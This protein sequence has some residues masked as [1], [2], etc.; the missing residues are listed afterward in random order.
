M[1][2]Y[3]KYLVFLAVGLCLFIVIINTSAFDQTLRPEVQA[4]KDIK[5]HAYNRNNAYPALLAMSST[6]LDFENYSE[7]IRTILN[8]KIEQSGQDYLNGDEFDRFVDTSVDHEWQDDY[9]LCN[10]RRN[11][12]CMASL[13]DAVQEQPINQVRLLN[14]MKKY[15]RL[16]QFAEYSDPTQLDWE[17]PFVP[18]GPVLVMKRLYLA[19]SFAAQKPENF[20]TDFNQDMAF[21]R[22]LLRHG[23]HMITK[24][25]AVAS[26]NNSIDALSAALDEWRFSKQQL[27]NLHTVVSRLSQAEA[28]ME[29]VFVHEFKYGLEFY[30]QEEQDGELQY[31]G[32]FDLYQP[33]ATANLAY[34]LST[35]PLIDLSGMSSQAFYQQQIS[36]IWDHTP[37]DG[38]S[39]SLTALYN[40]TGKM[41]LNLAVPAYTDYLA[42][43]HDLDGMLALLRLKIEIKMNPQITPAEVIASSKERNPYTGTAV[44][45]DSK[46]KRIYFDCA[47]RTSDVCEL[48]L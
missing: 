39:W 24:M 48:S 15:T 31:F 16:I 1:K 14:Q 38:F 3:L 25:V 46:T 27:Q 12:G 42:R 19:N 22:M 37:T 36:G 20:I 18:F 4:I 44:D 17:A 40:P 30:A 26:I 11:R 34:E 43:I 9:P 7:E 21:W 29:S 35:Q 47:D 23:H 45:Y 2:I 8:Q 5:A 13:F 41:L 6:R 10:S 32:L 33:N 28:D